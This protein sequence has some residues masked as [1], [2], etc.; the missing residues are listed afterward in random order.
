MMPEHVFRAN[1]KY[2]KVVAIIAALQQLFDLFG[3]AKIMWKLSAQAK[4]LKI[5][6]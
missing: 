5:S 2:V 1:W 3:L 4:D 6:F